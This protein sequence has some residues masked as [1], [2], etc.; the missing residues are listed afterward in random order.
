MTGNSYTT[1]Y[2]GATG[3]M[4]E[5]TASYDWASTAVGPQSDW[6]VSLRTLI[7]MM[8]NSKFPMLIFWGPELITFYNDAFRPSLGNDGKHPSSLGQ[9]GEES[10]AE[11]WSTIGPMIH[12]IMEGGNGVWFEDQKLPI[13]R[14]GKMGYAYWTYSF[15]PVMN[16]EGEVG[17]VLV[18]CVETTNAVQGLAKL[19][20]SEAQFHNLLRDASLGIIIVTGSACTV[21]VVN[22]SYAKLIGRTVDELQDKNLF[23]IIPEAAAD[24]RPIL[25]EVMKNGE[26]IRKTDTPYSVFSPAG[27]PIDGYLNLVLQPY[28]QRDGMIDGVMVL[29]Q[30][31]SAEHNQQLKMTELNKTLDVAMELSDLAHF[32]ID[33]EKNSV[34][35]SPKLK[36][37]FELDAD[38]EDMDKIIDHI[39]PEDIPKVRENIA[40][41]FAGGNN[42]LH[43]VTYRVVSDKGRKILHLHSIGQT[44]F[45]NGMPESCVGSIQ[46]VTEQ[47]EGIQRLQDS[48]SRFRSLIEQAPVATCLFV[49]KDFKVAVANSLML[50]YW[51]K[52]TLPIGKPVTEGVP[53]LK[54]QPFIDILTEVYT[55]GVEHHEKNAKAELVVDGKPQTFYFDYTYKPIF[56]VDNEIIGIIDM[57]IDVTQQVLDQKKSE[58]AEEVTRTA[59]EL[60]DLAT[61][62]IIKNS[63]EVFYS[64]RI[65]QWFGSESA[66]GDLHFLFNL[67]QEK[68]RQR[69][70]DSV[71]RAFA[72]G[73]GGVFDE[74]YLVENFHTGEKRLIHALAKVLNN[75]HDN[76]LKLVGTA[77]DITI[78]RNQKLKLEHEVKMRTEELALSL[79]QLYDSNLQLNHTNDQLQRSNED[80]AQYAYV[81]SHDLQEP[82]RK[83]RIFCSMLQSRTDLPESAQIIIAR[84]SD[85]T[86]R[87][88]NL[89]KDVLAFSR[90]QEPDALVTK[91]DLSAL[92]I[93][94][95]SDFELIIQ[96]KQAQINIGKLPVIEGIA[97]QLHQLF[98][99]LISNALKF[100][101]ASKKPVIKITSRKLS[102]EEKLNLDIK[103]V[104]GVDYHEIAF[105]DNGIGFEKEYAQQIF[106]LFKRLNPRED[107]PGTGIG[108]ALCKKIVSNH[109]G[110]ITANSVPG[111]GTTF[112][113]TLPEKQLLQ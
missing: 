96:E 9:R 102:P 98:Y 60:A 29:C 38:Q 41:S 37:W 111:E 99:N 113:I 24:F 66:N 86:A 33:L 61:W 3:E 20:K 84:I 105:S 94:I 73:I 45:K 5:L 1:T 26:T 31:V 50:K 75:D 91:T 104:D 6:P 92:T 81:A 78:Q 40:F 93:A 80:L 77:Q 82:L 32:K 48:E 65:K 35:Y 106:E 55:T 36:E 11:P 23:E 74:E 18:T 109:N 57:A 39:H 67:I 4:A 56:S 52:G 107:F 63:G 44:L 68:D 42:G 70:V 54:D 19:E 58:Q 95:V 43:D 72:A 12:S 53:E 10:W 64:E 101:Q 25:E 90:L 27:T 22:Q 21:E 17:G 110:E 47:I 51:G 7:S 46:N 62:S 103:V 49:G 108:L 59:V 13:Y 34:I 69:I 71:H 30:D 16:D 85:G 88:T 89:I 87:M 100:T 8:L 28:R 97:M 83:I 112:L 15:S 79:Q 14:E 76:D 2:L